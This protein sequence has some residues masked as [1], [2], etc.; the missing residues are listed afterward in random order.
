MCDARPTP[1]IFGMTAGACPGPVGVAEA[2][3]PGPNAD[4]GAPRVGSRRRRL[5]E[6]EASCHCPV[7]GTGVPIG[8]LRELAS[9]HACWAVPE[10]D[11]ALH[12]AAVAECRRRSAFAEA[13]QAELDR[14]A[15]VELR[16]VA[17][18]KDADALQAWWQAGV[19]GP[20]LAAQLWAVIGH[21]QCTPR[22]EQR[23]LGDVHMRQH[24]LGAHHRADGAR[25]Q[26]LEA[27]LVTQRDSA[28][29]ERARHARQWAALRERADRLAADALQCRAQLLRRDTELQQWRERLA[30]LE[31][32]AP[33]LA[34]RAALADEN[35]R[36]ADGLSSLQRRLQRLAS[37]DDRAEVDVLAPE[38][39]PDAT[40]GSEPPENPA[41]QQVPVIDLRHRAVLC[42]GGRTGSVPR[43]RRLIETRGGRF[44]HHD[45]G[46]EEQLAQLDARLAAA[47]VVVCQTGCMSHGAMWRVKDHC[48]RTGKRCLFVDTPGPMALARALGEA[49]PR[50]VLPIAVDAAAAARPA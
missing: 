17:R 12:S 37:R 38:R 10:D 25:L 40:D 23:V 27:A 46:H 36:L 21:P 33:G 44:L 47:D 48:R 45:G 13:V 16:T 2:A 42:V 1:H 35:R 7:L 22:V 19:D 3:P 9:R 50:R 41:A 30:A 39:P 26:A 6:L 15:Q 49:T 11:Y 28:E 5:W 24:Q 31:A 14:H 34:S 32:A 4:A 18:L 8:R 29:R 43:Y 20:H